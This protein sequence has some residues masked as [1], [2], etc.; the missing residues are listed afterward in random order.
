LLPP[1]DNTHTGAPPPWPPESLLREL[2]RLAGVSLDEVEVL[3]ARP[4]TLIV[5]A[6]GVVLKMHD[7]RTDED[8]LLARLAAA[9]TLGDVLLPPLAATVERCCGRLVT[10]WPRAEPLRPEE[11]TVPWVEAAE[12]LARLHAG[13]ADG[14]DPAQELPEG[15][16]PRRMLRAV[17]LLRE[18]PPTREGAVVL[19][20]FATLP[21]SVLVHAH[22]RRVLHGD[23][24]LGQLVRHQG[25]GLRLVD[26]D[27]VGRG[28]PAWDLARPAAWYAAGLMDAAAWQGFLGAYVA[29]G[30]V[31]VP[32][33]DPWP[34][35]DAPARALVIQSAARAVV[36]DG[37]AHR[38]DEADL[39]LVDTCARIA[40]AGR[41]ER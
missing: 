17:A 35:L 23:W 5:G 2:A 24:H 39:A 30:G 36:K 14:I 27:E 29:A 8:E 41:G 10:R 28:D 40:A 6:A 12:M 33:D 25:H 26:V 19:D 38:L 31:A 13:D 3:S 22:F 21:R 32:A 16:G 4:D 11:R 18:A 20:A 15:G 1:L 7:P 34:V 9:T 37:G